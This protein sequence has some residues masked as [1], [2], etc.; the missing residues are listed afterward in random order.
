MCG[1]SALGPQSQGRCGFGP[2]IPYLV[3]SPYAKNN[4]VDHSITD[5]S[6]TIK[7]IEDNWSLPRIGGGSAD[8]TAGSIESMFNFAKKIS[9]K[10]PELILDPATGQAKH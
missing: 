6:S 5:A 4:F 2:R 9:G 8:A 7:F 10:A 3:V 1:G